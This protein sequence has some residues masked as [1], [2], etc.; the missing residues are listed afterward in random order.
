M[1]FSELVVL[2]NAHN[3]VLLWQKETMSRVQKESCSTP[4]LLPA[5]HIRIV[6]HS[7]L[8]AAALKTEVGRFS[9]RE[10]EARVSILSPGRGHTDTT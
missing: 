2:K 6:C 7:Y 9:A 5:S 1:H 10:T 4:R 3:S 8:S